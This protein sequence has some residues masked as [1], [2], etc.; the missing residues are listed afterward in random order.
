LVRKS[1]L[2]AL[3]AILLT[4]VIATFNQVYWTIIVDWSLDVLAALIGMERANMTAW[5]TPYVITFAAAV[6]MLYAAFRAGQMERSAKPTLEILYDIEDFRFIRQNGDFTRYFVALRI[7][8]HKSAQSPSIR[9]IES[10]FTTLVIA[11][12]HRVIGTPFPRG[13]VTIQEWGVIHPGSV[14]FVELFG[15]PDDP[16]TDEINLMGRTYRFHLQ[17]R[18][19]DEQTVTVEFEYDPQA[20]P[21]IRVVPE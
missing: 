2:L 16:I 15:L 17:A 14:E 7:N 21:K 11:V 9:A 20:W 4:A 18:A 10:D 12:A 5:L 19:R 8:G 1:V 6:L 3:G 13:N